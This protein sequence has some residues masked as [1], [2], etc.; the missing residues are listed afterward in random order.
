MAALQYREDLK[1]AK[2][3]ALRDQRIDSD[4][5]A[6]AA[7]GACPTMSRERLPRESGLCSLQNRVSIGGEGQYD[8]ADAGHLVQ[9]QGFGTFGGSKLCGAGRA[10]F[11]PVLGAN[12]LCISILE[13]LSGR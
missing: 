10:Q 1:F 6:P 11:P 5:P 9:M 12:S 2:M 3:G 8:L 7:H 4:E 13:I